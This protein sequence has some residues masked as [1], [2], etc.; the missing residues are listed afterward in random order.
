MVYC[1]STQIPFSRSKA[2]CQ[3]WM[4]D[5]WRHAGTRYKCVG[6]RP[7][8]SIVLHNFTLIREGAYFQIAF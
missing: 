1:F 8:I 4:E 6:L 3:G 2:H 5:P 7:D